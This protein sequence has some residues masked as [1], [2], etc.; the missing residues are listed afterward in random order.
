MLA[1]RNLPLFMAACATFATWFG[2]ETVMGASSEFVANGVQGIIEDPFGAALCLFLVGIWFARPLYRM[3]LMTFCDFFRNRFG[4]S[5]EVVSAILIVPS[6]FGWIAA[7]FLALGIILHQLV[8]AISAGAG[9]WVG[10]L[11]V[12]GYSYIGGMWAVSVTDFVQ[13]IFIIVGLSILAA[14]LLARVGGGDVSMQH[15]SSGWQTLVAQQPKGFFRF[16]PER[17]PHAMLQYFAA[18]ITIGLG[19]I[20]QQDVFQR[21]MA[22]KNEQTAVRASIVASLMYLTI[23]MLPLLIALCGKTLYPEL[24]AQEQQHSEQHL[25]P[26]LVM[27][28]GGIALQILFFGALLSAILSTA[29]GAVLAPASVIG[30]NLIRQFRPET[31]DKQLLR[32]VRLSVIG[33]AIASGIMASMQGNIYELVG[34]SSAFSLVSLFVPLVAGLYWKKASPTGA[35]AAMVGGLCVWLIFAF[36]QIEFSML[37]GLGASAAAMLIASQWEGAKA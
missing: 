28:H 10:M 15:L 36:F 17:N 20:P 6:Y 8:P 22:S 34:Q 21:V 29:S 18:W 26:N 23:A 37:Y 27:Q 16:F 13:T 9:A 4:R 11:L 19:S 32:S 14:V 12:I 31:T 7:Q 25:I 5:A 30:E 35:V 33:V 2:T 3:N 1:G 24:L